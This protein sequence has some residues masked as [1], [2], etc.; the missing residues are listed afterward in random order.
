M[1]LGP[2]LPHV[3]N[4]AQNPFLTVRIEWI[5]QGTALA[6]SLQQSFYHGICVF[7]AYCHVSCRDSAT[8]VNRTYKRLCPYGFYHCRG[9]LVSTSGI[10]PFF[11]DPGSG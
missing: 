3:G 8:G 11:G 5:M 7:C 9:A 1:R 6:P 10:I 4:G 2:T